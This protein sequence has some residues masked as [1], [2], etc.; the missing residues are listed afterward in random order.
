MFA[1]KLATVAGPPGPLVGASRATPRGSGTIGNGTGKVL[2]Q[3]SPG[4][5]G[6]FGAPRSHRAPGS[7]TRLLQEATTRLQGK[8][9]MASPEKPLSMQVGSIQAVQVTRS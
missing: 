6:A 5:P 2:R 9:A 8:S 3:E 1:I 4:R 7:S